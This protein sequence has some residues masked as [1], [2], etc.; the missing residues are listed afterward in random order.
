V[1]SSR[2]SR[3]LAAAVVVV[4][5]AAAGFGVW[6][7]FFRDDAPP[8]ASI[9]TASETLAEG[10]DQSGDSPS[11]LD[12]TWTINTDCGSDENDTSTYVGYRMGEELAGI[13]STTAVGRTHDVSGEVTVEGDQVTEATFEVDMTTLESDRDQ[14][15]NALHTRG[16]QT[17]EFP[18][19]TFTLT[20]P[21]DLPSDAA[22]S[23]EAS[24]VTATGE[25]T[26][27]GVTQPVTIE[28]EAR[29]EGNAAALVGN[30][31]VVLADYQIEAPTIPGR[32]LSIEDHGQL[33]FQIF[34]SKS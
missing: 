4:I 22:S 16:L 21:F 14:R 7:A 34:L 26:L 28:I 8:E 27:H 25:L 9:D 30:T 1:L 24:S 18:T 33:E 23:G 13:G 20:E 3:L 15:D 6:W 19:A 5:V 31:E 29:L 17:D 10:C 32:V 2:R 12:G 11:D